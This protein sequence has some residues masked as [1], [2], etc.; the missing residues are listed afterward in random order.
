M[1]LTIKT[2]SSETTRHRCDVCG[3]VSLK[4]THQWPSGSWDGQ[5]PGWKPAMSEPVKRTRTRYDVCGDCAPSV[6]VGP[7]GRA[8]ATPLPI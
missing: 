8:L 5:P 4:V 1:L 3:C 7:M 2:K 6:P